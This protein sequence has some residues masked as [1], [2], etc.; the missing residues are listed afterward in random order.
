MKRTE[1]LHSTVVQ[2]L[3]QAKATMKKLMSVSGDWTATTTLE[4]DFN[5]LEQSVHE[6]GRCQLGVSARDSQT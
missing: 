4:Y 1:E 5:S 2:H 3:A 6:F